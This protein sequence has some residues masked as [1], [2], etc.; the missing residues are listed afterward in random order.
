VIEDHGVSVT[1]GTTKENQVGARSGRAAPQA[2]RE[3][4]YWVAF[5]FVPFVGPSRI[6]R[7]EDHFGSLE[8]A[9][10]ADGNRLRAILD[11][12]A[13]EALTRVR[14]EL[15]VGKLQAD[16]EQDGISTVTLADDDYPALLREAG[17]PPPVLFYRGQLIETDTTA[18]AIVGT[19]RVSPY[20][21]EVATQIGAGLAEAGVTVVSGLAL[22]IDGIAHQAALE[23]GGRTIAVLGGGINRIYPHEHRG[24]ARRISEQ[25]AV[26]SEYA[27]D[28]KPDAPNFPAR[29][30]IISGLSLGVVVVEAPD[31]SGALI[32]VDFAA[33][34]GRDVFAVAGNV[35]AANSMGTNRLIRD[36]A[37]LVRSAD[38]VLEDLQLRRAAREEPV[39]QA[40]LLNEE[41]RRLLAVLTGEPQ[42]I[43]DIVE[44]S[45]MPLPSVSA[46]LLTLE[47]QG[48]VRN[49]GAQHYTRR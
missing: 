42:H 9:W 43:D 33:D 20:G 38:D 40:L 10:S 48:L 39:Q 41:D 3:R 1:D 24:L 26:L 17:G 35:T 23:A 16:L 32:T 14:S 4:D 28:R 27:P 11:E 6:R 25:G 30:R 45:G 8:R 47:L 22:G 21:R 13:H 46:Q 31:R 18:V 29:N 34:Q 49:I 7:L 37:R 44:S 19:R 15:D 5:H 2:L 36:G 12:R